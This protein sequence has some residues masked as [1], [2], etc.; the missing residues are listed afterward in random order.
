MHRDEQDFFEQDALARDLVPLV[1][2]RFDRIRRLVHRLAQH[3]AGVA[4]EE[5]AFR[6]S[7]F[8]TF[9]TAT[10]I[11]AMSAMPTMISRIAT[12]MMITRPI[13]ERPSSRN[14]LKALRA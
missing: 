2:L 8:F 4:A 1:R 12:M 3:Y 7:H 5:L 13:F 10:I 9:D 11:K 14:C 6:R